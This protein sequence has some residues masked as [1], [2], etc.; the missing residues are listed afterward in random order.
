MEVELLGPAAY[1]A[2]LMTELDKWAALVKTS[3]AKLD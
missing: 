2:F 3:G 1:R